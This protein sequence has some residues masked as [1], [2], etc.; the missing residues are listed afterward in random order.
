MTGNLVTA[1]AAAQSEMKNAALNKTNP[2]FKSK[3]ADLAAIRDAVVPVLAKHGLA[4]TQTTGMYDGGFF[5]HTT[6]RHESGEIIES[7]YPLP[8]DVSKPQAMG[9]ALTYAR[10]YSLASICGISAEED[11]DAN[12]AQDAA[13]S[14]QPPNH[15]PEKNTRSMDW[16]GPLTKTELRA[17]VQALVRRLS[18]VQTTDELNLLEDEYLAVINQVKKDLPTWWDERDP[19]KPEF[20]PLEDRLEQAALRVEGAV[21]APEPEEMP[22]AD[23]QE[24]SPRGPGGWNKFRENMIAAIDGAATLDELTAIQVDNTE[25][26]KALGLKDADANAA[27]MNRFRLRAGDLMQGPAG[28]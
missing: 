5:L 27:I 1:L 24:I 22:P 23:S 18:E 26:L 17:E 20:I 12:A 14:P 4:I 10:R 21:K 16:T 25:N 11:D 6:L 19:E 15:Q 3:Y 8:L 13:I 9:S 28:E 7:A 2:H